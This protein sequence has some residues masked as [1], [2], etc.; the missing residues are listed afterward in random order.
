MVDDIVLPARKALC[1]FIISNEFQVNPTTRNSSSDWSDG[2]YCILFPLPITSLS[3]SFLGLASLGKIW[4]TVM[5]CSNDRCTLLRAEF[6]RFT[7]DVDLSLLSKPSSWNQGMSHTVTR[8]TFTSPP[9]PSTIVPLKCGRDDSTCVH[10][11]CTGPLGHH[12]ERREAD[13]TLT[14]RG[15]V[16]FSEAV[17]VFFIPRRSDYPE[18]QK[19]SMFPSKREISANAA[20]NMLE[21]A[22][23]G[24]DWRK[25][26]EDEAMYT[27]SSGRRVHPI[28]LPKIWAERQVPSPAVPN[29]PRPKPQRPIHPSRRYY[30]GPHRRIDEMPLDRPP[31]P[32]PVLV[33]GMLIDD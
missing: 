25:A 18:D 22:S 28:H 3:F 8:R 30:S 6:D 13:E 4:S 15:T 2:I 7:I 12:D 21:F 27:D 26:T 14:K 24:F 19:R 32:S 16:E 10:E 5:D 9:L 31:T 33:D 1:S 20:R 11:H 29:L 23:D 17:A